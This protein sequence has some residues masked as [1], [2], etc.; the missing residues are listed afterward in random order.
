ML[1]MVYVVLYSDIWLA[2]NASNLMSNA[3]WQQLSIN[4]SKQLLL[5]S[6]CFAD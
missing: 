1:G 2:L 5:S 3:A 6:S 4:T